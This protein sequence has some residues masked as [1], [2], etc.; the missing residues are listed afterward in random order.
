MSAGA[1][2]AAGAATTMP[3]QPLLVV[4]DLRKYFPVGGARP[5]RKRSF[6]HAVDQISFEVWPGETL[7]I[8][9]ESGCGK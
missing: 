5:T 4:N 1:A 3:L 9:G 8:V 7:G 6:V 2:S